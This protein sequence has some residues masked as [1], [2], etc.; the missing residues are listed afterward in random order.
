[1]NKFTDLFMNQITYFQKE[2]GCCTEKVVTFSADSKT[3]SATGQTHGCGFL[4]LLFF[5]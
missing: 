5:F 1:M 2:L 3:A 4:L